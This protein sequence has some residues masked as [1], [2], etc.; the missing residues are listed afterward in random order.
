MT[1]MEVPARLLDEEATSSNRFNKPPTREVKQAHIF[2]NIAEHVIRIRS[3]RTLS[4]CS[5]G[6]AASSAP[7]HV[8]K[9]VEEI[10]GRVRVAALLRL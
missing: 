9:H 10:R 7:K 3:L 5:A 6:C 1:T 2:E 8:G 4:L